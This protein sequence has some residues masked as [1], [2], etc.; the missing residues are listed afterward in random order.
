[1]VDHSKVDQSGGTMTA[2]SNASLGQTSFWKNWDEFKN[3][4]KVSL[5]VEKNVSP[6]S[7]PASRKTHQITPEGL[8]ESTSMSH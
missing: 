8:I 7:Q 3:N 1:M 6:E 5:N 4:I 2:N